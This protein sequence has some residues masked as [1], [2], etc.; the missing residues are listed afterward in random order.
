MPMVNDSRFIILKRLG[1]LS[2]S[3]GADAKVKSSVIH[4]SFIK[5]VF[6]LADY[7]GIFGIILFKYADLYRFLK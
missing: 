7:T 2:G 4:L 3:S 5:L 6:T 1:L